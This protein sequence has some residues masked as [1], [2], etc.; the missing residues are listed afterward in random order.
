MNSLWDIRIFLGLVPK[1]SPC[2]YIYIHI[3]IY[4]DLPIYSCVTDYETSYTWFENCFWNNSWT[5]LVLFLYRATQT[6]RAATWSSRTGFE[7]TTLSQAYSL[8]HTV[9]AN[10]QGQIMKCII[11]VPQTKKSTVQGTDRCH[12]HLQTR[13]VVKSDD[14]VHKIRVTF[15]EYFNLDET[16]CYGVGKR[17]WRD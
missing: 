2:I 1:E 5:H 9:C 10:I 15:L 7:T 8:T 12:G 14:R 3:Y 13:S 17:M 4:R 6:S 16:K 11:T